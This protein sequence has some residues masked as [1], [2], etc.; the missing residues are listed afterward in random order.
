M[1]E[2]G[3]QKVPLLLIRFFL[4]TCIFRA[5]SGSMT[6]RRTVRSSFSRYSMSA[7]HVRHGVQKRRA[8]L[9]FGCLP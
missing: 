7:F 1:Q 6:A 8:V 3:G 2:R 5:K 4:T 9:D